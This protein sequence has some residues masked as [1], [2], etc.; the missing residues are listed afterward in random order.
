MAFCK[1]LAMVLLA[2]S[3]SSGYASDRDPLDQGTG[4]AAVLALESD[5]GVIAPESDAGDVDGV[6]P[7]LR[8]AAPA[9][10]LVGEGEDLFC[11]ADLRHCSV[12]WNPWSHSECCSGWCQLGLC[13]ACAARGSKCGRNA[14]GFHTHTCCKGMRCVEQKWEVL[15]SRCEY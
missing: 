15:T 4:A 2:S 14:L 13:H 10:P 11:T 9:G 1:L 5:A 8:G 7:S 6:P 3:V 12:N